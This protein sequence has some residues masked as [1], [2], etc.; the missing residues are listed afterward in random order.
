MDGEILYVG[1]YVS[2]PKYDIENVKKYPDVLTDDIGPFYITE[3]LHGTFCG[4]GFIPNLEHP[5][6]ISDGKGNSIVVFSKGFGASGLVFKNNENNAN[7][8]YLQTM[9]ET[10]I[11]DS[12]KRIG[13]STCPYFLFGEIFGVGVQ[14]LH[15]SQK[16]PTF[17]AFDFLDITGYM[18]ADLKYEFFKQLDIPHVPILDIVDT[19][20]E[21][22][23]YVDGETVVGNGENIREGVVVTPIREQQNNE[24]G[25]VILKFVSEDYLGRKG[26]NLTEFQ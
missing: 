24:L 21:V 14:D 8:L 25:R 13:L 5:D 26:K 2:I 19:Q 16:K 18:D 11:I 1:S 12:I 22:L 20:E 23:K 4:I 17:R 10:G 15:Y 7:N 6:L 9:K 3:K